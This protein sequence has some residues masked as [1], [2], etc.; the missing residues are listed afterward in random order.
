[1][2]T[3]VSLL[4][5]TAM[6]QDPQ[7]QAIDDG[8]IVAV[9][10]PQPPKLD[11]RID[12]GEWSGTQLVSDFRQ[13]VPDWNQPGT[14]RT[15]VRIGYTDDALYVAFRAFDREPARIL[16][17]LY[18]RDENTAGD[19]V[20]V[21]I[22][23]WHDRRTGFRFEISAA[24]VMSDAYIY[25]DNQ[26]DSSWDAT[27]S[28]A[29]ARDSEGWS[30]EFRIPF[31]Q[32]RFGSGETPQ[33][34]I[35]L[36]RT[37]RR[38]SEVQ[39]WRSAPQD[40]AQF[41]SRFGDLDGIRL[42]HAPRRVEVVPYALAQQ[43][44]DAARTL[45]PLRPRR[46]TGGAVG[47]DLRMG[48]GASLTLTA[49]I[50]PDFGQVDGDPAEVNLEASEL[51][52]SE[53][54]PFFADGGDAFR[55]PLTMDRSDNQTLLYSRRIGRAP[56][57]RVDAQG[58]WSRIP[59]ETTILGAAKLT[60][61]TTSGWSIGGLATAT[62][63]ERAVI[64]TTDGDEH[65]RLVEPF[66]LYA[67]GRVGRDLRGGRTTISGIGTFVRRELDDAL[68]A[69]LRRQ[70]IV[71]GVALAHRWGPNDTYQLRVSAFHSEVAGD[72]LAMLATQ[73][74]ST[75]YLQRPD[76][77]H[78][79]VDSSR[80][81]L[82]GTWGA[83]QV[84]RRLGA[85]R[86]NAQ[87]NGSTPG[88]EAND[89]GFHYWSGRVTSSV[90]VTRQ[91]GSRSWASNVD[92]RVNAIDIR[93]W[94]AE[95]SNRILSATSNVAFRNNW[96][97]TG[98]IAYRAGGIDGTALRGGPGLRSTASS[99]ADLE[100][101]S[102]PARRV[103]AGFFTQWWQWGEG[104]RRNFQFN[105]EVTYQP[106]SQVQISLG[107]RRQTT[108]DD[109][110]FVG[111][112][113]VGGNTTYLVGEATQRTM[114]LTLRSSLVV[115][116]TLSLQLWAEPFTSSGHYRDFR[117]VT[118]ARA[119]HQA[120]RFASVN[121]GVARSD[122]QLRVDVDGDAHEDLVTAD[123]D[124][125]SSSFQSN[126]VLRWEF[127]PSSTLFLVWQQQRAADRLDGAFST[128]DALQDLRGAAPR[129]QLTAKVTWWW[130]PR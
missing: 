14:E 8:R 80:T 59:R 71:G 87:I 3:V 31:S 73:Q 130:A 79:E 10:L 93:N 11:G 114:S 64:R 66:T 41:V 67:A 83:A 21:A 97:A 52:R 86:W 112:T 117:R 49:A 19:F 12:A 116:P 106:S 113:T 94:D 110:T 48:L 88:F 26:F 42:P 72:S 103:R 5:L 81:S 40:L 38:R 36:V 108:V 123:P 44:F 30:A 69:Q 89:L 27:W 9:R 1:M 109:Q 100:V 107:A 129:N 16:A 90:S 22:D 61:V 28:A 82:G 101:R 4:L 62:A 6:V 13:R 43:R 60:G 121:D 50:N 24:G 122:G 58:G 7:R 53:R 85:W 18:R 70:A 68:A 34:G 25:D 74:A 77:V 56:Q 23:S 125:T 54:R 35:N 124:F 20:A 98:W 37:V 118:S 15:E 33:F 91:W 111:R 47:A 99:Y 78:G 65:L 120:D 32:L 92:L 17:P 128:S 84:E 105:P 63:A 75:R 115:S 127:R 45:D 55:I 57:G 102:D 126:L 119:M 76:F 46:A 104:T 51:F 95:A 96:T 2:V 39:L 29:S